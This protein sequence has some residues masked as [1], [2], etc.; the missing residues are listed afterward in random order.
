MDV[1]G[2]ALGEVEVEEAA[3]LGGR[4]GD[5]VDVV[6]GGEDR[7]EGAEEG[8][9]GGEGIG[10]ELEPP[11][12]SVEGDLHA[13]RYAVADDFGLEIEKG[14]PFLDQLGEVLRPERPSCRNEGN[15]FE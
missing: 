10:V 13:L 5:E 6:G 2:V 1:E 11:A 4:S 7:G 12:L 15:G 14:S 8:V 3:P 9:K